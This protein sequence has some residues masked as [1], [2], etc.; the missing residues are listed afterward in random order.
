MTQEILDYLLIKAHFIL[1]TKEELLEKVKEERLLEI[2][3]Y[4]ICRILEQE[5]FF[6]TSDELMQK[7]ETFVYE[8]RFDKKHEKEVV[9]AFNVMINYINKYKQ[10]SNSDKMKIGAEWI[11]Q[12]A[13]VRNLP[14]RR[15]TGYNLESIYECI[16]NESYYAKI[17]L[18]DDCAL[19]IYN[20]FYLLTTINVLCNC[21]PNV[22]LE[23]LNGVSRCCAS[24]I[25]IED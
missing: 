1:C 22:L 10:L 3:C 11:N 20:P 13:K 8:K 2:Y 16:K 7:L 24:V 12:E 25:V 18:L 21:Y 6:F 14:F 4:N 23:N 15:F 9:L 17:L 5:Q 19:E